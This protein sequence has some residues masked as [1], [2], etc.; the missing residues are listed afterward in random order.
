MELVHMFV[1]AKAKVLVK[2]KKM[3]AIRK[4]FALTKLKILAKN[5]NRNLAKH[6]VA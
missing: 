3:Q 6:N 1:M 2:R 4:K 5:V